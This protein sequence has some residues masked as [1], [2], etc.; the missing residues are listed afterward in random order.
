MN[1][2]QELQE[3][4][5]QLVELARGFVGQASSSLDT[6]AARMADGISVEEMN[7]RVELA[8]RALKGETAPCVDTVTSPT[9]VIG[10][11]TPI[12]SVRAVGNGACG[13]P[14]KSEADIPL[15]VEAP[16]VDACVDLFKKGISTWAS[17]AN[18]KDVKGGGGFISLSYNWLSDENK[19]IADAMAA[20]GIV[21]KYDE[22]STIADMF[23]LSA[24]FSVIIPVS[25]SATDSVGSISERVLKITRRFSSQEREQSELGLNPKNF[26]TYS[27]SYDT[28]G[29]GSI[30]GEK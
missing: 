28:K 15:W 19:K 16:L 6:A 11:D 27:I 29:Y 21:E 4:F 17:S 3:K 25:I 2:G 30:F 14:F 18:A 24:P 5:A 20:E 23:G 8:L 1:P 10:A 26:A 12:S 13:Q 22:G 7:R 9:L